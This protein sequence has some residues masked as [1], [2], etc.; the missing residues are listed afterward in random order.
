MKALAE[1]IRPCLP[2]LRR[3]AAA[4]TGSSRAGDRYVELCLETL[5]E[6]PE[7]LDMRREAAAQLFELLHDAID[8]CG[9]EDECPA[10]M[11]FGG[12]LARAVLGLR[13]ID[14]RLTLLAL[15]E[16]LSLVRAAAILALPETEAR[17]R[18]A[19]ARAALREA[20]IARILVIEDRKPLADDLAVLINQTG[21]RLI[22]VASD[23][24]RAAALAQRRHP[25]LIVAHLHRGMGGIGPVRAMLEGRGTP[26]VFL[27][28]RPPA[29]RRRDT[30]VLGIDDLRDSRV[31]EDAIDRALFRRTIDQEAGRAIA[32]A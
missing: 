10:D 12:N 21:H 30:A 20:C 19:A 28:G 32:G 4:V 14:R 7:R 31:V 2:R 22:G 5:F 25:D 17:R 9:L 6:E 24:R 23:T 16:G 27:G 29:L 11:E 26:V 1:R 18:L 3:Y 15:L 8:A 13:P